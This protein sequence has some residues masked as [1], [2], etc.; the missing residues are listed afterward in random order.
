MDVAVRRFWHFKLLE[1]D[2][3]ILNLKN[4]KI[5]IPPDLRKKSWL[6]NCPQNLSLE[7]VNM[8]MQTSVFSDLASSAFDMAA[9]QAGADEPHRINVTLMGAAGSNS[10]AHI[11]RRRIGVTR[12]STSLW[13][14]DL[15]IRPRH[16]TINPSMASTTHFKEVRWRDARAARI[17]Q[18]A[19][20]RRHLV[21]SGS[22][23][24]S[25]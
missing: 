4:S 10:D 15:I 21:D 17:H 20:R 8:P 11:P 2:S 25:V 6:R 13:S 9:E 23:K 18:G 7:R 24:Y 1:T 5:A 22:Q 14:I 12:S 19:W 16:R 3:N